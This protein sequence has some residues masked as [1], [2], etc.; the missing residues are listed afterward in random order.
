MR[1]TMTNVTY[2][3]MKQVFSE[4]SVAKTVRT[5]AFIKGFKVYANQYS[6]DHIT[7]CSRYQHTNGMIPD[8]AHLQ[9]N[10]TLQQPTSTS[11]TAE[12]TEIQGI[13]ANKKPDTECL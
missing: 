13:T 2:D 10:T 1:S 9:G 8:F 6:F 11:R 12:L 4:Y 5:T 3:V 7:S